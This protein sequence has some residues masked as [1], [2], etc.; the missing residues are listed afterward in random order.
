MREGHFSNTNIK[1]DQREREKKGAERRRG[2]EEEA[3][4]GSGSPKERNEKQENY[5]IE[6]QGREESWSCNLHLQ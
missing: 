1:K 2:K 3:L 4:R 6:R 5:E